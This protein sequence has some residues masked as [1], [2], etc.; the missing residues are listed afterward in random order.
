VKSATGGVATTAVYIKTL[1]VRSDQVRVVPGPVVAVAAH[2]SDGVLYPCVRNNTQHDTQQTTTTTMTTRRRRQTNSG[3][4]GTRSSVSQFN[5]LSPNALSPTARCRPTLLCA[6]RG[7]WLRGGGSRQGRG[8]TL[9]ARTL[10]ARGAAACDRLS[11]VPLADR[12]THHV[13]GR[14]GGRLR[15]VRAAGRWA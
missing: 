7:S 2:T 8:C 10:A 4:R 15:A 13:H 3:G 11:R 9:A 12:P 6:G 5:A 1:G 14:S